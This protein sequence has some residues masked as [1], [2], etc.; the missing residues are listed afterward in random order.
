VGKGRQVARGAYRAAVG[1]HRQ[2]VRVEHVDERV[3]H[4]RP[5][6]GIARRQAIGL[7]QHKASHQRGLHRPTR[8]GG[9]AAHEVE[10]QLADLFRRYS[11]VGEG[12]ESRVDPVADPPSVDHAGHRFRA[13]R[14]PFSRFIREVNGRAPVVEV[15]NVAEL[16]V[17]ACKDD[18]SHSRT[19]P[20]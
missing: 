19:P 4:R 15:E 17:A 2:D 7:E 16:K 6:A 14:H 3:D 20:T 13:R 12:A 1:D 11:L 5:D 8:A 18:V 10:L 9:V